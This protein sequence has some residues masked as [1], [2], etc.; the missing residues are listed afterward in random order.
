MRDFVRTPL[1]VIRRVVSQFWG[2]MP[3]P[4][5]RLQPNSE[6]M[7]RDV[8][9]SCRPPLSVE[10]STELVAPRYCEWRKST[11]HAYAGDERSLI[12]SST[13]APRRGH[14][15]HGSMVQTAQCR[16]ASGGRP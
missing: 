1:V 13:T 12:A 3:T 6:T 7:L 2:G 11:R 15:T 8:G 5:L 4:R 9:M 16:W 10:T 14:A